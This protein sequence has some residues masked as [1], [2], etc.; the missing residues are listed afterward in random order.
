MAAVRFSS[1]A[2]FIPPDKTQ[3]KSLSESLKSN[4]TALGDP[5]SLRAEKSNTEPTENDRPNKDKKSLKEIAEEK[6]KTNPSQLGDPI[7]LK[8]E[9]S[10]TNPTP[11]E[12]G[13]R[14]GKPKM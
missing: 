14:N 4:P 2:L 9:T 1:I 3:K 8:A 7:S 12:S 5:V 13:A 10:N 11:T 6:L